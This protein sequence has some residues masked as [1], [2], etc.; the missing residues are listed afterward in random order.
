MQGKLIIFSGPS[1]SGKTTFVKELLTNFSDFE[2]SISACSRP[3]RPNEI[4]GKDYYFLSVEEFK[5]KIK[6]NEFIEWQEVYNNSFYGTLKTEINR[7]HAKNKHVLFDVDVLGGLN[8]KKMYPENSLAIF[9]MPPSIELL[10]QRLR[11]RLTENEESLKKRLE[12]ANYEISFSNQFDL[13]I[14][15]NDLNIAIT[16][17]VKAVTDFLNKK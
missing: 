13:V 12:K 10:E 9:V 2:F 1:G 11:L 8:I 3:M 4:N 6:N 17:T 5:Q 15:N 14:V 16:K 7:I